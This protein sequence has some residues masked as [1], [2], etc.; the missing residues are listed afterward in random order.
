MFFDSSVEC[1][2]EEEGE[3][4]DPGA[5][6]GGEI[7]H[8]GIAHQGHGGPVDEVE[9]ERDGAE[10]QDDFVFEEVGEVGILSVADDEDGADDGG[11]SKA[12][13]VFRPEAWDDEE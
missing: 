5:V 11:Q 3:E 12:G 10:P 1:P 7:A 6:G 8:E 13:E 2:G 9:A 4:G